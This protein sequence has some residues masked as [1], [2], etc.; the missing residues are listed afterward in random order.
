MDRRDIARKAAS[1]AGRAR[2][3][4][5]E[6]QAE[7]PAK[8]A[9]DKKEESSGADVKAAAATA[10]ANAARGAMT[11]GAA[12]AVKGV[13]I[14]AIRDKNTRKIILGIVAVVLGLILIVGMAIL[15]SISG[16]SVALIQGQDDTN[17]VQS[18]REA[19]VDDETMQQVQSTEHSNLPWQVQAA[20]LDTYPEAKLGALEDKLDELD[21]SASTET[22]RSMPLGRRIRRRSCN[23][24]TRTLARTTT[25]RTKRSTSRRSMQPG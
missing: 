4:R 19:G 11:G 3:A 10:V 23:R 13:A 18:A 2:R 1:A 7:E 6:S 20:A 16:A 17:S 25:R 15:N 14:G 21:P 8:P 9:D 22:S 24:S 12:G 5:Q